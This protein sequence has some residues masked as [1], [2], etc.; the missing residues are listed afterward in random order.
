MHTKKNKSRNRETEIFQ[1][2]P[3]SKKTFRK[4]FEIPTIVAALSWEKLQGGLEG[5]SDMTTRLTA[6][7]FEV[8]GFKKLGW[9]WI[10][11]NF[12]RWNH[13]HNFFGQTNPNET[14]LQWQPGNISMGQKRSFRVVSYSAKI[15]D[16][17]QLYRKSLQS[18][19]KV[20]LNKNFSC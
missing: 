13:G 9:L 11:E 18:G 15:L 5:T 6:S 14:L 20:N 16:K 8:Q 2:Y 3:R 10:L 17:Q 7:A 12:G 1:N 19:K 4:S